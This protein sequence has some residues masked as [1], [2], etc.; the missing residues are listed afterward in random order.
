MTPVALSLD[1]VFLIRPWIWSC[2]EVFL[3]LSIVSYLE[4]LGRRESFVFETCK[5]W[6]LYSEQFFSF[7]RFLYFST[8]IL[9]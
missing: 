1:H 9:L 6:F 5:S 2:P 4:R 7:F 8:H 3:N